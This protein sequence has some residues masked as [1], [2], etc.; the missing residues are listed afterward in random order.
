[1]NEPRCNQAGRAN[2]RLSPWLTY[3]LSL[4]ASSAC[5]ADDHMD[6]PGRVAAEFIYESAPFP[7]CHASTIVETGGTLVVAWFGGTH[8]KH[9]DVGIWLSRREAGRWTT[10]KQ[11]ANGEQYH[12]VD[13]AVHRFPTWNPVLFQPAEG[14]LLLFYKVGPS[15]STWWGMLTTSSDGGG[16]WN[17]PRRLPDGILGP[18]KNKPVQL[19]GGDLLCPSSTEST[20]KLS[21]WRIHFERTSDLGRTWRRTKAVNDGGKF[22]AIQPSILSHGDGKL[23]AIGRTRQ[24]KI[25]QTWSDDGGDHW[26]PLTATSLPNPNSGIDAV[27]LADGRHLVVYNHASAGRS[28]LNVAISGDGLDWQAAL[29]LEDAPGEYSYPAVI[30][31]GDGL[32]HITYTWKRQRMRHVVVDPQAIEP[33]VLRDSQSPN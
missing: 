15:P 11:V 33:R 7:E 17:E 26:Q 24:G 8:E 28:P 9:P 23:Q 27:T 21:A 16:T 12:E 10:P 1:M 32:V 31:T 19:A 5:M 20:D 4:V 13:G 30:Q 6:Q 2:H 18:I 29:I 3:A 25:F 22:G 14:P